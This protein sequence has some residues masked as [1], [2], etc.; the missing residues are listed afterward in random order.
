[1]TRDLVKVTAAIVREHGGTG[2]VVEMLG[3]GKSATTLAHELNG[4]G[5]AKLGLRDAVAIAELTHDL[6]LLN[7]HTAMHSCMVVPLPDDINPEFLP[8]GDV[9]MMA[10]ALSSLAKLMM[11]VSQML[12]AASQAL[13]DGRVTLNELDGFDRLSAT[14]IVRIQ[15][16]RQQ[17][18]SIHRSGV[19]SFAREA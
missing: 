8:S 10:G 12:E 9:P 15:Q 11:Q 6:R 14:V 18:W 2:V 16:V 3:T 1:M 5:S 4:T 7:A 19:P 13:A 17:L